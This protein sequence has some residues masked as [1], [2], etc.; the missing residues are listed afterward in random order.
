MNRTRIAQEL[1]GVARDITGAGVSDERTRPAM[2]KFLRKWGIRSYREMGSG[3]EFHVKMPWGN[4]AS[5]I[6]RETPD[7][8]QIEQ[9]GVSR[10]QV[11]WKK[12]EFVRMAS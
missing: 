11:S 3:Y 5:F 4:S 9:K 12:E 2:E 10:P 1:L 7:R 8:V 6:F